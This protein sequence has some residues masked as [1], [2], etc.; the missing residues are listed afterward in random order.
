MITK[1]EFDV[2]EPL[3]IFAAGVAKDAPEGLFMVGTGDNIYWVAVKGGNADWAMYCGWSDCM[4]DLKRNGDKVLSM[5]NVQRVLSVD[6][7]VLSRYRL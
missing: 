5:D 2:I 3:T 7:D 4:N 1:P 6:P